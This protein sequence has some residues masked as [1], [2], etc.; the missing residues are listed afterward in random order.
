MYPPKAGGPVVLELLGS[1]LTYPHYVHS[2]VELSPEC[3]KE[4][5]SR[6]TYNFNTLMNA[7]LLIEAKLISALR[8][9]LALRSRIGE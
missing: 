2:V 6:P 4:N 7:E 5:S 8:A 1:Q 9:F 3:E